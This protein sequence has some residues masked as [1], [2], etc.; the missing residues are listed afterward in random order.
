MLSH[1]ISTCEAVSLLSSDTVRLFFTWMIAHGDNCGRMR[2]D[3]AW[4]RQTVFPRQAATDHQVAVWLEELDHYG[5]IRLYEVGGRMFLHF[6]AWGNF[7]RLDRMK[8]SDY[9]EPPDEVAGNQWKP[10]VTSGCWKGSEG[11]GSFR[12]GGVPAERSDG[13]NTAVERSDDAMED[14]KAVSEAFGSSWEA[15]DGRRGVRSVSG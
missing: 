5:L 2:A 7:Q 3:P 6:P 14:L 10:V 9:P 8:H 12:E 1:T 11:K 13:A 4:V 15:L